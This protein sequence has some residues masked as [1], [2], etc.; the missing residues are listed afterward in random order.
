MIYKLEKTFHEK[1]TGLNTPETYVLTHN[2]FDTYLVLIFSD[3][4]KT[5]IY[6]MPYR[7]GPHHEIEIAM[8]FNYLILVKPNEHTEDYYITKTKR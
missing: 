7:E 1:T 5:Q 6:K 8:S 4:N 3:L 2:R